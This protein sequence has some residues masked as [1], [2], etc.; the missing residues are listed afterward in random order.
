[1]EPLARASIIVTS[2]HLAETDFITV[3]VPRFTFLVFVVSFVE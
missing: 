1:M 3:A 2:N